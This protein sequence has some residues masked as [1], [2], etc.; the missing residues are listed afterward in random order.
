MEWFPLDALPKGCYGVE[1]F[2][3]RLHRWMAKTRGLRAPK[4][5]TAGMG[6]ER[7]ATELDEKS[8]FFFF[9]G[10][11]V[12]LRVCSIH[13]LAVW[14]VVNKKQKAG[15]SVLHGVGG[16]GG[17]GGVRPTVFFAAVPVSTGRNPCMSVTLVPYRLVVEGMG[18]GFVPLL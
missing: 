11:A 10:G 17:G 1:P 7:V 9:L 8:P 12:L 14:E 18:S 6:H 5:A 3:P 2:L 4:S 13:G 15:Q 16:S